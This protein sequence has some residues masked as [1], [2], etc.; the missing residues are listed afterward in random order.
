MNYKENL[1]FIAECLTIN[2][3]AKNNNRIETIL[4]S[5]TV[6]W[7]EV[8]K[9]S[10]AQY[11]FPALYYNLKRADF[12]HYLPDE[13]VNYMQY[14]SNLN[15]ERN[16]QIIAQATEINNLLQAYDIHPI[17]L[18]GT[19]NLLEGLY[20]DIGERM[21]GDIDFIFSKEDYPKV[22]KILSEDGYSKVHQTEYDFPQFKHHPRLQKEGKIAAVEI[23]KELL[24]EKYAKE[25]NYE[26]IQK[27]AQIINGIQVLSYRNQLSLSII[28]KQINDGGLYHKNIALRNAYD[29]FLLSK[30]TNALIAFDQFETLKNPL[31]CFLASCYITF[32]KPRSLEYKTSSNIE[33]YLAIFNAQMM[34]D[35]LRRKNLKSADK[36]LFVNSR[37]K[38]LYKSIV[39]KDHRTWLYKRITDKEWQQQKLIQLGLKK[40]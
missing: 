38:I 26:L 21:V 11:V 34:D 40:A 25:F 13:L 28:A 9:L 24:L 39:D 32:N 2:H 37:V 6:D 1:F 19:G 36:K 18:K 33:E 14:I 15:K 3:E 29:V 35:E 12:L 31:T 30:K 7:D 27:D 22:I 17:F 5:N 16:E 20:E 4:K 10:T 23:H 8:V